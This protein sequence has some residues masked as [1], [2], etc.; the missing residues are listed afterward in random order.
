MKTQFGIL[1]MLVLVIGISTSVVSASVNTD[2]NTGIR[3]EIPFGGAFL[4]FAGKNG[5]NIK[6][7]ELQGKT[8]LAVEGCAKGSKIFSYVLDINTGGK[9]RTYKASSNVL[10][11]EMVTALKGLHAGDS[12]EFKSIKAN[13]PNNKEV[14]DVHG[15]KYVIVKETASTK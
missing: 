11:N 8:E 4:I 1:L 2:L 10:T 5:G 13:L 14:V 3:T 7:S 6:M 12:F 15:Y 9:I